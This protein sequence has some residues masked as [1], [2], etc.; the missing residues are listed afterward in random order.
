[1]KRTETV[2]E[3]QHLSIGENKRIT[4]Q[5][6][7]QIHARAERISRQLRG[8]PPVFARTAKP[9]LQAHQVVGVL[10]T[11]GIN[12]EILPKID[13]DDDLALRRS[14]VRMLAVAR[15][16]SIADHEIAHLGVQHENLLE[17]LIRIFSNHLRA[18]VRRGL[19]HRYLQQQDDLP[20][21]KGKLD[22]KRQFSRNVVRPDRLA[23]RYD[24]FSA[25]TPLNRVLK[26]ACA[27]LLKVATS[28][29]NVRI[30]AELLARFDAAGDS[31]DPLRE[32]VM[33]DRTNK[34]F[35]QLYGF[36]K[37]FLAGD[38][39]N[40]TTGRSE[41][42]SLLFPMNDLFEEY[43][44]RSLK[45]ALWSRNI[46]LQDKS[47][48]AIRHP[49]NRFQLR[50]DIVVDGDIIVD[51]KWKQLRRADE[52]G[53]YGVEQADIYQMLAYARAYS[54]R[55]VILLYPWH[56]RLNPEPPG[57]YRR[58]R[59]AGDSMSFDI[60]TVD[61][62]QSKRTVRETLCTII[63]DARIRDFPELACS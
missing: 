52:D 22:V 60:A 17:I 18:A 63:E 11:P 12:V 61:V 49:K 9:S 3:W 24:E 13:A 19:P 8:R 7:Q 40:T 57:I 4:A 10:A 58:W 50:P 46:K 14:L 53:N 27:Q 56:R 51:T 33:L 43:I 42:Y 59:S 32:Q 41:G 30:L 23:C 6:A 38:R 45:H 28:S 21:L 35:H 47:R 37:L 62:S 55:R 25:D 34:M 2:K 16:L 5:D 54:A 44:G 1:M 48:H 31:P 36:A 39:Q 29:A 15:S 26:A 20:K